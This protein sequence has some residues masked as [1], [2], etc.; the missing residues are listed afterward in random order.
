M[1]IK[2][3]DNVNI[4]E[5]LTNEEREEIETSKRLEE[6][7]KTL[8][9]FE[10]GDSHYE[11]PTKDSTKKVDNL[12]KFICTVNKPLY[13]I[14]FAIN[15]TVLLSCTQLMQNIYLVYIISMVLFIGSFATLYFVCKNIKLKREELKVQ[16]VVLWKKALFVVSSLVVGVLASFIAAV[17][18]LQSQ[19][20]DLGAKKSYDDL[21]KQIEEYNKQQQDRDPYVDELAGETNFY[22]AIQ[23]YYGDATTNE[24]D[25]SEKE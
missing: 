14:L 18:T 21:N 12:S 8:D 19:G 24:N 20:F 25:E 2:E 1:E 23:E 5:A 11:K 6:Q 16:R 13:F 17:I 3:K 15:V 4:D 22:D 7:E 9:S 10:S